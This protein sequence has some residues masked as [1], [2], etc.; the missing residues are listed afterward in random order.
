MYEVFTTTSEQQKYIKSPCYR[1]IFFSYMTLYTF[2]SLLFRMTIRMNNLL[3]QFLVSKAWL[4][5]RRIAHKDHAMHQFCFFFLICLADSSFVLKQNRLMG[6][7]K[8][9]FHAPPPPPPP[10][11]SLCSKINQ[12]SKFI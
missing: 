8:D 12:T 11:G 9:I 2:I 7:H 3:Q 5:C 10:P 1:H 6:M 4:L